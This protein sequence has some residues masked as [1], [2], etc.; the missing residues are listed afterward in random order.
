MDTERWQLVGDIFERLLGAPQPQRPALLDSLCG[1][2]RELKQIVVSMLDSEESARS[3][4][5]PA[6]PLGAKPD[7]ASTADALVADATAST[8]AGQVDSRIG[9]WRLVRKIGSGGMGIVWLAERADGQFRQRAALKLI[10]RGMDSDAVL[11]RFLRERQILARLE[12]PHIAHLLDG[13][14]TADSRPYFAMEYVEGLPLLDYC[15]EKSIKLEE[16]IKLFLDICAAVQFAHERHVVHRD[17]KPSNVLIT[18]SGS[19]KLLD[20]GIAKLLEDEGGPVAT[21]TSAQRDQPMTP[22]YAAPEQ[23]SGEAISEATDVYAL[24]GV[25]Y[26]LFTDQRAH[27]FSGASDARDV[28]RIIQAT[29]PVAPSRIKLA[30]APVPRK[31][32][33]GDLDVI[34]LTALRHQPARRY[35]SV[36][37]LAS[38]LQSYLAGQPIAARR[39]HVIY[40]S[41][42]FLRRHRMG[43]AASV[44]I[45]LIVVVAAELVSL[46]RQARGFAGS[47]AA[48]AI[49]DFS[50]LAQ[51]KEL[52]WIAPALSQML[53]TELALGNKMHAVP[54]ELVRSARADLAAPRV[55]GYAPQSLATLR[56]RLGAD[57]VLSGS[58]LVSGAHADAKLRLDLAMQDARNGVVVAN[59]EKTG[60]LDDMPS[61]VE[62]AGADLRARLGLAP[63]AD[64][65]EAKRADNAQPPNV[66]IA[67]H[68][69]IAV[70]ALRQNDAAKARD[71]LLETIVQAPGYAPAYVYLAQAWKALGYD[72][73]ALAYAQQAVTHKEGLPA[74]MQLRIDRE[75]AV[76]KSEW[77]QALDLDRKLLALNPN[78]PEPYFSLI[79][80]LLNA[81]QIDGADA[82][83]AQLRKLPGSESEPRVELKAADIASSRGD[84]TAKAQ[85]AE[86]A[87]QQARARDENTLAAEAELKL[88][89]ARDATGN[90]DE[91]ATLVQSAIAEYQAVKNPHG[92][93]DGRMTLAIIRGHQNRP[94][95]ELE[96]Y[97]RTLEIYQR[98]GDRNRVATTYINLGEVLQLQG[99]HDAALTASRDALAIQREIMDIAGQAWSLVG[100]AVMQRDD[101]AGDDVVA[102]FREAIALD[103]R[104][105]APAHRIFVIASL[106]DTLRLRGQLDEA[107]QLC[108]QAQTEGKAL[109]DP[110]G[111]MITELYCAGIARDRGQ[112]DT[113]LVGFEKARVL[114][115]QLGNMDPATAAATRLADIDMAQAR[116]ESARNRLTAALEKIGSA[117]LAAAEVN[118]QA[119][120]ALCDSALNLT[121]ERD[122]ALKRAEELRSRV[123]SRLDVFPADLALA[124]LRGA[125]GDRA[126]ALSALTALADDADRRHW[127]ANSLEARLAALQ[128]YAEQDGSAATALRQRIEIVARR[129][130]FAWVLAR[131]NRAPSVARG[132][133][134]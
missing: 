44:A 94:K 66:E 105:G 65:G 98:I 78:N 121:D 47:N 99:E 108:T 27:D 30:A 74:D 33:R 131:M 130:G 97:K 23:I 17:I 90:H 76:Q 46:E 37:A 103:E 22:A 55:G 31:R 38:D 73:K 41:Y 106:S 43:V 128:L 11:A 80:D 35:T 112:I 58:Y 87:L 91:A 42:K 21:L 53:S 102:G 61:L 15:R 45:A 79:D 69:G 85:H 81:G 49:V 3:G 1:E 77:T 59:I 83:L 119:M 92:E 101:D 12:H 9:P 36:A 123:S 20:F 126:A 28:L 125:R 14:I 18:A 111:A 116:W 71:E 109:N 4:E 88:A 110:F 124:Q 86:K 51:N 24:G 132:H 115:N 13:G 52:A 16:R 118:I 129:Q 10:K 93:A 120:L 19:V 96:E 113:A 84:Q 5:Q 34:V 89:W 25:L 107:Q 48:L 127:V 68:M 104:V 95:E 40:R 62:Q 26:E 50:D 60:M 75:V 2:D 117:D 114:A 39:D 32:L 7:S 133:D 57:Y 134:G 29:D 63:P 56:K 6:T 67:R 54:D 70:D 72:A 122:K 64:T 100:L 8:E 82:A